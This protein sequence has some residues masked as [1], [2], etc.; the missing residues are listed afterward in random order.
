[1]NM[2]E[3][4]WNN[5]PA[6]IALSSDEV[7]VWRVSLDQSQATIERLK[8]LLATDELAKAGRFRFAKDRNQFIIGRG[9]LRVLLGRY[10]ACV[11]AQIHFRYSSYGKPSLEDGT[12][13]G[14]QFNLSHSHQMALLAF[15]CDRNVGVD[16]EY[17]RPDVEFEQL[18]QHFFSPTECAVLLD[19]APA[20][21]KETFYN[22][23]TRKEAYIKARGEGLSMPLDLFDVSL[24][25]GEPAALLQCRE[26]PAEVARWSLHALMP[27]EQ[28]AAALAVEKTREHTEQRILCWDWSTEANLW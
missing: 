15:A 10:L 2:Q 5:P 22:C 18:A 12:Q 6:Q 24:R 21:R 20:L 16:I 3:N 17:M 26:N 28:Y 23:W 27:G 25:P 11:P 8:R 7:H 9:L 14:L 19:M 1:M 4:I 13:A